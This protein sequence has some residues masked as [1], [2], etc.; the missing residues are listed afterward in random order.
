MYD[1]N[2]WKPRSLKE[3]YS[4]Y[5]RADLESSVQ[6]L[7]PYLFGD[8]VRL[9]KVQKRANKSVRS[10]GNYEYE[11]RLRIQKLHSLKKQD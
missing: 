8:I 6:A 3:F 11:E 5:V 9:E 4:T 1:S 10:L 2:T 7:C